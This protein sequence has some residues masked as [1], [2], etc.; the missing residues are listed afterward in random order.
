MTLFCNFPP[1]PPKTFT[2]E[3]LISRIMYLN[4]STTLTRRFSGFLKFAHCKIDLNG[5][6]IIHLSNTLN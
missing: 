6:Y 5:I 2:L 1:I 4:V 3:R